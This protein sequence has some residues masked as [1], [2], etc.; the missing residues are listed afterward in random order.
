MRQGR[1]CGKVVHQSVF[2]NCVDRKSNGFP[3]IP[4][5]NAEWMGNGNLP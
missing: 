5:K 3:P 2:G 1:S 4:Q